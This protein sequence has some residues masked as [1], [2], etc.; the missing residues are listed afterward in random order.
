[1]KPVAGI[2]SLPLSGSPVY[3]TGAV[4]SVVTE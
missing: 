4:T 2:V 3:V 1:M